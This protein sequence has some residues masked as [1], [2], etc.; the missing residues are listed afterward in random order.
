MAAN[1]FFDREID[2][3]NPR[4][5]AARSPA[6]RSRPST[7]LWAIARRPR[8]AAL[9]G[10]DAQS[11]LRQAAADRGAAACCSIRS[12]NASPGR[13]TSCS[14]RSTASR[15]SAPTSASPERSRC[16]ALLLFA[17]VTIWVAGFDIIYALMDLGVDRAQGIRSLPARFGEAS[18]RVLPIALHVAMLL[19][20]ARAGCSPAPGR[21]TMWA[22]LAVAVLII[23]EE[24]L[25]RSGANLFVINE[26]VFLSNMTFSV[27]FLI[28]TRRRV[29]VKRRQ[30]HRGRRRR[31]RRAALRRGRA[32]RSSAAAD[33]VRN[34]N[35]CSSS[36]SRSTS[37]SRAIW[38]KYGQEVVKGVQAAVDEQNRFNAPISHVWGMRPLD[39]RNDPGARRDQRQRRGR[40]LHGHRHRRQPHRADDAR[41]A[42]ALRQRRLRRHRSDRHRRRGHQARLSQ[43]LSSA[44]ERQHLGTAFRQRRARRK[45]GVP[46]IAV[47]FDGDYG[48]DVARGFVEQAQND[49]HPADLLLFP[50]N[51]D[52]SGAGRA[53][54]SRSLPGLRLSCGK[55][56]ELGPIADALRLAGYTGDFGASDGFY[57]ADTIATYARTLDGAYVASSMPPLDRVPSAV[58][59]VTDFEREVS[60]ITAF[61]AFGYAAAQLM[62]AASQRGNATLAHLAADI[63]AGGR[64]LYDARRPVCLQHQR[65]SADPK[66]L[67]L[68]RRQRRLQVR[69]SGGPHRVRILVTPLSNA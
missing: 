18:G 32:R 30:L 21:P 34:S 38:Q 58:Q 28:T 36:R 61:S 47:A 6:A 15:R 66:H 29:R 64:H 54:D 55:T 52:R 42:L 1:R 27:F 14:A 68:H 59:L 12:A 53:N 24:H 50:L 35:I 13:R 3:R 49:R 48:Y 51:E 10:V 39:D 11:A 16:P 23:Y 2:A 33:A 44:G 4:T 60:Q 5:R 20:L 62:I 63:A 57:N 26:R 37:R 17:A 45:R 41:R 65:R 8:A 40:R 31:G 19:L 25:F 56:A 22:S 7:M 69:P 43:R 9:G 67:S 46:A